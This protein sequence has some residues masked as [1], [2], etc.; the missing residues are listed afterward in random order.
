MLSCLRKPPPPLS[1]PFLPE[2]SCNFPAVGL[3]FFLCD[4][5]FQ[6]LGVVGVVV[7]IA[8]AIPILTV[9]MIPIL[10]LCYYYAERYLQVKIENCFQLFLILFLLHVL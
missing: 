6:L 8:A 9:A 4:F 2:I 5:V 3:F 7:V 10:G 1:P